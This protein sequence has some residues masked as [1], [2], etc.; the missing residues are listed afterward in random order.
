MARFVAPL[1]LV[2]IVS[3]LSAC[4]RERVPDLGE[5]I[6]QRAIVEWDSHAF[7]ARDVPGSATL[8]EPVR[9][10]TE[11]GRSYIL[12]LRLD[13]QE[14]AV[15]AKVINGTREPFTRK[16]SRL[17]PYLALLP[18]KASGDSIA[19]S[20]EQ[21]PRNGPV[22]VETRDLSIVGVTP[23]TIAR[24]VAMLIASFE[25][26][27]GRSGDPSVD[28]LVPN[29]DFADDDEYR[30][31][32]RDWSIY[33]DASFDDASHTLTVV[34]TGYLDRPLVATGPVPTST[35]RRY[36]AQC[37]LR[38]VDGAAEFRAVD[39]DETRVLVQAE[40]VAPGDSWA[41]RSIEFLARPEDHAVRLWIAP[42]ANGRTP[43]VEVRSIQLEI[44]PE[45]SE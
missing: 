35:G 44:L 30:G 15:I 7:I 20:L 36:R 23:E 42:L 5:T 21:S 33:G 4:S 17:G 2:V 29:S 18:V 28:N 45:S 13:L 34:G 24:T 26:E 22:R 10:A 3:N 14:G 37:D 12:S 38:V 32:P 6:A 19:L 39:Y 11:P 31:L 25:L 43:T 16:V 40:P 8:V 1:A 9:I 41:T 27:T